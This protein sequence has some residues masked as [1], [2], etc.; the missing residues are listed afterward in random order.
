MHNAV[1]ESVWS[2]PRPPRV[3]D[4]R[5]AVRVILGGEVIA[6]STRAKRVLETSHP[7]VYYIPLEDVTPRVL[8][9]S[10]RTTF[11]EFKGGARYYT[12]QAGG[13]VEKDAAWCYPHPSPGFEVIANHV[14]F[15]P[16]RMDECTVDGERVRPQAGGF[17]GGWITSEIDGPFKGEPGTSGW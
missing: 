12:V 13:R 7:P 14:A 4:S 1:R 17:Y 8:T 3:E 5:R 2:Y 9:P 11:C 16:A 6:E 15:Y 10:E